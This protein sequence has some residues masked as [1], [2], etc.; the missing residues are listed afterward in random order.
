MICPY[1]GFDNPEGT[2]YC[3]KCGT[4]HGASAPALITKTLVAPT[5]R[6]PP[7]TRFAGR[8]E[9]IE[10]LGRGGMGVVY[11]AV[12]NKLKRTVALKFLPFEWTYDPQAKERFVREAQAA[13][14]LD[15]PNI[16]TVHEIDE[17]D[18]RMFISM[19]FIEGESL[20]TKIDGG[21]LKI[22]EALDFGMQV[23]EGLREAHKKGVIHRDIKS[24]NIMVTEG[25]QA[26]IMDFGLARVRGG[27]LLTK[28]GMTMGT[29]AYMS[30]EQAR[31]ETVDHRSDI[32]SLGVVLYEMLAGRLPFQGEHDQAVIY[33]ILKEKPQPLSSVRPEIPASVEQVVGKAMEKKPEDRYQSLEELIDDLKSIAAGIEPER[34]RA[35]RHKAR[36]RRWTRAGLYAGAAGLLIIAAL[37]AIKLFT[38]RPQAIRTLAVLPLENLSG[39]P[40]QEYFSDG[41]HEALIT[42][43]AQLGSLKRVIARSSVLRFKGTKTPLSQIAQDLKVD[44]LITGAVLRSGD[45]VRVT[46]QLIN[47]ATEAQIWAQSYERDLR[48]VLTLQNEIVSAITREVNV[49]LTPQEETRLATARPVNPEAYDLCLKGRFS[50]R[51]LSRQGLDD[52]LAYY[53]LALEKDPEYAPAYAGIAF[54]WGGYKQQGFASFDEATPKQ[55]AAALKALQLDSTLAEVHYVLASM[56]T[57]TDWD[58]LGAEREYRRAIELNP[59]YPDARI[60]YAHF[61]NYMG[62]PKEA[63]VEADRALELDPLNTLVQGIYAMYLMQVRRYDDAI[64]LLR[65]I[66]E[67]APNDSIALSTLRSAYHIKG[68]YKEALEIWKASYAAKGDQEAVDALERGFA[69][70]GYQGAL[71]RLAETLVTRSQTTFV[72]PWQIATLFTRA[73][74]NKE[75]I[76]WL[77]KAHQAH[78]QNMPYISVDPIF[79][80]LRNE[81][82]F[83]DILRRMKLL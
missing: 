8:Y 3:G 23:A 80:N 78:D 26:K 19:A 4:K 65:K 38:G 11:K 54:V 41:I 32:W 43:L 17:A 27:T 20:K 16:C 15:H 48:D 22:D 24:A 33:A 44:G 69:E 29:I 14:V 9:I 30:P 58:W 46:A 6:L 70:G 1:C 75:A 21:P 63:A 73:G 39:D 12:D 36:V 66:L 74:M 67:T 2:F 10:E 53:T 68:M 60:Y 79:D 28:E 82:R 49:R 42:D 40:Q 13:A 76:D 77:E 35:R 47:P 31:G 59:N 45:R 55:K 52:A 25:G 51:K 5:Q 56:N 18:D 83:Q 7:G 62:R 37:I 71:R 64:A 72:T 34:V 57:W 50:W 81:P 61:L